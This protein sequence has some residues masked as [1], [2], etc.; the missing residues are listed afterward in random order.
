VGLMFSQVTIYQQ[1]QDTCVEELGNK[2]SI[3]DRCELF[4]VCVFADP[5]NSIDDELFKN[6]VDDNDYNRNPL[7][8]H[9]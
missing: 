2:N 8:K 9:S 5:R 4:T 7:P 6:G 1:Q 3:S